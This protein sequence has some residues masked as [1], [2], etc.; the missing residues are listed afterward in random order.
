MYTVIITLSQ[1][2]QEVPEDSD[3]I[4]QKEDVEN[5]DKDDWHPQDPA[6]LPAFFKGS[7]SQQVRHRLLYIIRKLFLKPMSADHFYLFLLMGYAAIYV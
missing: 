6:A 3:H 2:W 7:V 1:Q 5:D 4:G